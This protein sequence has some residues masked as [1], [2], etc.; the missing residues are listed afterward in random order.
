MSSATLVIQTNCE[1]CDLLA[2]QR[3]SCMQHRWKESKS[4]T[5]SDHYC[6]ISSTI[7]D[8][9]SN[10]VQSNNTTFRPIYCNLVLLSRLLFKFLGEL[11]ANCF[12]NLFPLYGVVTVCSKLRTYIVIDSLPSSYLI[13]VMTLWF[14]KNQ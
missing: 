14:I 2:M 11:P 6:I 13:E 8:P 3:R 10:Q 9:Y 12:G 7:C 4:K 5:K 1:I